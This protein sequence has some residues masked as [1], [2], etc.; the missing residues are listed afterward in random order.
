MNK[1]GQWI[2]RNRKPISFTVGGLNVLAGI[3]F[4]VQGQYGLAVLWI[5]IGGLFVWDTYSNE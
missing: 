5:V 1:I 4:A 3:N 2:D